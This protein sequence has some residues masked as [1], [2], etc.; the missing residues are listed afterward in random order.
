MSGFSYQSMKVFAYAKDNRCLTN[1]AI[2]RHFGIS[3]Q[4]VHKILDLANRQST[5]TPKVETKS[6]NYGKRSI[7]PRC[8]LRKTPASDICQQC[9]INEHTVPLICD[10]CGTLFN[11][12]K[13]DVLRRV[14]EGY[15]HQYC[16]V[17]CGAREMG[18]N[19]RK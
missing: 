10:G 1:A 11:R 9:Y 13:G 4:R 14:K 5:D 18:K 15:Q 16:K 7:C 12:R 3:R 2:G 6:L 19:N 17:E 8:G